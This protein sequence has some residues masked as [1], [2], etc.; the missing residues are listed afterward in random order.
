MVQ[1]LSHPDDIV[2]TA[3]R[4]LSVIGMSRQRYECGTLFVRSPINGA[5]VGKLKEADGSSAEAAIARAAE[6]ALAWRQVPYATRGTLVRLVGEQLKT[7]ADELATLISI[8]TGKTLVDAKA[9][10]NHAI[11]LCEFAFGISAQLGASATFFSKPHHRA[12]ELW[13]PLGVTG[14]I[15]PFNTPLSRFAQHAFVSLVCGNSVVWK[16]SSRASLVAVAAHELIRQVFAGFREAPEGLLELIVG[17]PDIGKLVCEDFRIGLL[18]V[19]A[20]TATGRLISMKLAQR[21]ARKTVFVPG[22]NAGIVCKSADL[23]LAALAAVYGIAMGGGQGFVNQRRLFVHGQVYDALLER[24]RYT[25][26]QIKVGNPLEADTVTGPL[27]DRRAFES[28]QRL[29]QESRADRGRITGGNR[30]EE[31]VP[32]GGYYV[33]PALV[34]VPE[35]TTAMLRGLQ[36]PVLFVNRIDSLEEGLALSKESEAGLGAALFTQDHA[37]V[38]H[39]LGVRGI[40]TS[41]ATVNTLV[42]PVDSVSLVAGAKNTAGGA[43]ARSRALAFAYALLRGDHEHGSAAAEPPARPRQTGKPGAVTTVAPRRAPSAGLRS[44]PAATRRAPGT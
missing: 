30:L 7:C 19:G 41:L 12:M 34:E 10:T 1:V 17:G 21:F 28:M 8:E 44:Q 4:A 37:E 24:L 32:A 35:Q 18:S 2:A 39:F 25:F 27:V 42:C 23:D 15:T 38:D 22:N 40:D 43:A 5:R 6:A 3:G 29:L 33:R 20:S 11:R 14:C 31:Q 13:Q 36:C 16:P 26:R 9:E